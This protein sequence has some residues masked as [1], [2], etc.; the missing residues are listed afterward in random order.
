MSLCNLRT[1]MPRARASLDSARP[2]VTVPTPPLSVMALAAAGR[3]SLRTARRWKTS[4]RMPAD[5]A[6][7]LVL[8]SDGLL[9]GLIEGW[10]GFRIEP[11]RLTTPEGYSYTASEL[12]ALTLKLELLAELQRRHAAGVQAEL[13]LG[14]PDDSTG[15][16]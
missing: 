11:G 12:R 15:G 9:D 4:G 1:F 13:A 8:R 2:A 14:A 5:R 7:A 6:P 3:V 10:S 16:G